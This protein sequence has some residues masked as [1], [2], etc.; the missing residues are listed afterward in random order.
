M[1]W[2]LGRRAL[3]RAIAVA[4][5]APSLWLPRRARAEIA[6]D[7]EIRSIEAGE[8]GWTIILGMRNG[9]YPYAGTKWTDDSTLVFVPRHYRAREGDGLDVLVHF[10][11]H[12]THA[13]KT[14]AEKQLREQFHAGEQNAILVVP[15]GPV[16]ANDGRFGKLDEVGGLNRFL[17]ELRPA[18]QRAEVAE[19]LGEAAIGSDARVGVTALSA[20]SG[21]YRVAAKCVTHGGWSVN[22]LYLFDALYGAREEFRNWVL[23]RRDESA[24]RRRHKL[25]AWYGV[26]EVAWQCQRLRMELAQDGIHCRHERDDRHLVDAAMVHARVAFIRAHVGHREVMHKANALRDCLTWSCFRRIEAS[27]EPPA[28]GSPVAGATETGATET[29]AVAADAPPR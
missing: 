26:K 11:G 18:L 2:R 13:R 10:H 20:H 7:T 22:E 12:G 5:V 15:Q 16:D 1:T 17:R 28:A 27:A 21:G 6:G 29:G 3:T 25:M 23:A 24:P 14:V 19:A 4:A 8:L 9:P